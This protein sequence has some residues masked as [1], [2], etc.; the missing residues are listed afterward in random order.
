MCTCYNE[1]EY[2]HANAR[3]NSGNDAATSRKNLVNFGLV[4]PEFT[5]FSCV[6][7][8]SLST[9]V[10]LTALDRG[11]AATQLGTASINTPFRFAIIR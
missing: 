3:I 8:A 9:R 6:Q 1:F 7:Q 4:S 2:R 10:S 5:K 11:R